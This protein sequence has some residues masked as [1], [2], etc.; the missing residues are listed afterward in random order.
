[1]EIENENVIEGNLVELKDNFN[2]YVRQY[3]LI[4]NI[5]LNEEQFKNHS[6]ELG[7]GLGNII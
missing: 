1:M 6:E 2:I 3:F 4:N 7:R 5:S